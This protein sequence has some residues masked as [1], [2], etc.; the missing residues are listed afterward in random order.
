MG[1]DIRPSR[2]E[3]GR[4]IGIVAGGTS[5][6]RWRKSTNDPGWQGLGIVMIGSDTYL[7]RRAREPTGT[8]PNRRRRLRAIEAVRN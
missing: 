1:V 7:N 4:K 3:E 8:V 5:F 6:R 2:F